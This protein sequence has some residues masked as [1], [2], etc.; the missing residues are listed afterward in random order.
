[1]AATVWKGFISFG[2]VSIPVAPAGRQSI[3][4]C[5]TKKTTPEF[6]E[7]VYCST[8][9][10]LVERSELVKGYEY[11]KGKYVVVTP[12]EIKAVTPPN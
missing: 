6:H 7:V 2:L 4:I 5:F 11:Q 3:F 9:E 8:E 12:E 10:K 1:M